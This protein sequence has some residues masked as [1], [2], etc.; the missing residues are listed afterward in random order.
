MVRKIKMSQKKGNKE[1]R[2]RRVRNR[3]PGYVLPRM[4]KK[5]T[6]MIADDLPVIRETL[7]NIIE[8]SDASNTSRVAAAQAYDK[9]LV[10][11]LLPEVKDN[12]KGEGE[13]GYEAAL[14]RKRD[15]RMGR[16]PGGGPG[17][18][19]GAVSAPR[20]GKVVPLKR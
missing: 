14:R 4:R 9:L 1:R 12:G 10:K 13:D 3:K 2:P 5:I 7:M 11:K 19:E 18:G 15:E 17:G 16:K 6:G 8:D 20:G